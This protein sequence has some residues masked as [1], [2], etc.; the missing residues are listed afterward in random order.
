MSV[1]LGTD[2]L[3][4]LCIFRAKLTRWHLWSI[5]QVTRNAITW[6]LAQIIQSAPKFCRASSSYGCD[7]LLQS[8]LID[9]S[10]NTSTN[11]TTKGA[12]TALKRKAGT[13]SISG[14]SHLQP[15]LLRQESRSKATST[16]SR[17]LARSCTA[18]SILEQSASSL[19]IRYWQSTSIEALQ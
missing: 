1:F 7:V 11:S 8:N 15:C 16:Q 9:H 5:T 19:Y 18:T 10:T 12:E 13:A 4:P 6:S 14:R 3:N 17:P 2:L